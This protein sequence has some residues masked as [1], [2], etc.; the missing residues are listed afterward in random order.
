MADTAKPDAPPAEAAPAEAAPAELPEPSADCKHFP[1]FKEGVGQVTVCVE[2]PR[3]DGGNVLYEEAGGAI[4]RMNVDTVSSLERRTSDP[5]EVAIVFDFGESEAV[6][7]F[8]DPQTR[9]LFY[10]AM[11]PCN[12]YGADVEDKSEVKQ[13]AFF[14]A[15]ID[16]S[17][18]VPEGDKFS[19]T[20]DKH[21]VYCFMLKGDNREAWQTMLTG[22]FEETHV[23]KEELTSNNPDIGHDLICFTH[24]DLAYLVGNCQ[25]STSMSAETQDSSALTFWLGETSFAIYA[26]DAEEYEDC[27]IGSWQLDLHQFRHF[28][29]MGSTVTK[30]IPLSGSE[31]A[32]GSCGSEGNFIWRSSPDLFEGASFQKTNGSLP[33]GTYC[34]I[35]AGAVAPYMPPP[36]GHSNYVLILDNLRASGVST[37]NGEAAYVYMGGQFCDD[38]RTSSK[39]GTQNP[40]WQF[41]RQIGGQ[42]QNTIEVLQV[43]TYV[44]DTSYL[45]SQRLMIAVMDDNKG[46]D[47]PMLGYAFLPLKKCCQEPDTAHEFVLDMSFFMTGTCSLTGR[48]SAHRMESEVKAGGSVKPDA[49]GENR[50][51][52]QQ[53]FRR[54]DLDESGTINSSEELQQLCTNLSVRLELRFTVSDI[55]AKVTS[56]GNME[57]NN[58]DIDTFIEWFSKEFEVEV[59]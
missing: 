50:K 58:W 30:A 35:K 18:P 8:P 48:I 3:D 16:T 6:Y 59:Q 34:S 10:Q 4:T 2:M 12:P 55:D 27:Y 47:D 44:S 42:S 29:A 11:L 39:T 7:S 52:I 41:E 43:P 15:I 26:S 24:S 25:T 20:S 53:Y 22:Y 5:T 57:E 40:V 33:F 28:F 19:L 31:I 51:I 54:Y 56:A 36:E 1:A 17:K 23:C 14:L 21:D 38:R 9:Q 32:K 45:M 46:E 49:G 13:M 37:E